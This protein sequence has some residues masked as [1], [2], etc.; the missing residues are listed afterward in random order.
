M[1]NRFFAYSGYDENNIRAA[2]SNAIITFDTNA[3]L[4]TYKMTIDARRQFLGVLQSFNSRLWM[5]HQV[6]KEFYSNRRLI[7]ETELK[8]LQNTKQN[9]NKN[10]ESL[11]AG[12]EKSAIRFR[13]QLTSDLKREVNALKEKISIMIDQSPDK[14]ERKE[15]FDG[16]VLKADDQI[17]KEIFEIFGNEIGQ[18][19]KPEEIM[20]I[21]KEGEIRYSLNIPPGFEDGATKTD[22]KKYGDLVLWKE[23]INKAKSDSKPIIFVTEDVKP[24]WWE[25]FNEY[26]RPHP[27]LLNEFFLLSGQMILIYTYNEFIEQATAQHK[28]VPET[29]KALEEISAISADERKEMVRVMTGDLFLVK[30]NYDAKPSILLIVEE[31]EGGYYFGYPVTHLRNIKN[32]GFPT[33]SLGGKLCAVLVDT[34]M[35]VS[36]KVIL[37][38]VDTIKLNKVEE[39]KVF[40]DNL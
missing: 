19:F 1:T 16:Q 18:G 21:Y 22:Y 4:N 29:S 36:E 23:L 6:G 10:L 9:F 8:S 35:L 25:R 31:L 17:S 14:M 27:E 15:Y 3:L 24:D 38:Y 28:N 39:I 5:P 13:T 2:W 32:I 30:D 40:A 11:V 26:K 37:S 33:I 12:V 7:I 34:R 20:E